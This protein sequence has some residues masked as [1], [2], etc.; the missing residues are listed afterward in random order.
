M[1]YYFELRSYFYT[2]EKNL[3]LT[4]SIN[5][6]KNL[7]NVTLRNVQYRL[8]KL[9]ELGYLNYTPGNGRGHSSEIVY[10]KRLQ[11]DISDYVK[12]LMRSKSFDKIIELFSLPIP[13]DWIVSASDNAR[14]IVKEYKNS[15]KDTLKYYTY[16]F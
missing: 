8:K 16:F 11:H 5:E 15:G 9:L 1:H 2:R 14:D 7:W 3:S 10:F 4:I 6:I 13:M 12:T